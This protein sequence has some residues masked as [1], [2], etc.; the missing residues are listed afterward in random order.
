VAHFGNTSCASIP[1]LICSE[2]GGPLDAPIE[3]GRWAML[4]F[5]AGWAW[6]GASITVEPLDVC[7]LIEV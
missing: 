5:G 2:M 7:E 6:A 1:L 4:G 3:A